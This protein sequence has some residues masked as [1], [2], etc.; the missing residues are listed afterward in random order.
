[1]LERIT[2]GSFLSLPSK[3]THSFT[4]VQG[5]PVGEHD[6]RIIVEGGYQDDWLQH[7]IAVGTKNIPANTAGI[8]Q[9]GADRP[10]PL[11]VVYNPATQIF[12]PFQLPKQGYVH[13]PFSI[14]VKNPITDETK[15]A[16][17]ELSPFGIQALVTIL[18][19]EGRVFTSTP[20]RMVSFLAQLQRIAPTFDEAYSRLAQTGRPQSH[21]FLFDVYAERDE[22][23]AN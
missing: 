20:T 19:E 16:Y 7:H 10:L 15:E 1:M 22:G 12:E 3:V 9:P 13:S 18:T 17:R 6:V 8:R 14:E 5:A 23:S 4:V 21:P 11:R 2:V